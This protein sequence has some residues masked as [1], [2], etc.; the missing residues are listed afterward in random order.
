MTEQFYCIGEKLSH[1]WS[2]E[3]HARLGDY[4]YALREL[5]PDEVGPFLTARRF[6]GLNVTI[7]YKQTVMPYLDGIDES[8]AR[9]GAVNTIVNRGGK[10]YGYNTDFFGMTE[11]LARMR[12]SLAGKNVAILGTGGTSKTAAAVAKSQ[13]AARVV[14]VSRNPADA[15][16][17]SYAA[18]RETANEWQF[19]IN[20][21]PVGMYPHDGPMPVNP[22]DFP[23]LCGVL[24]AVYHPLRTAFVQAAQKCGL[25]AV[26]GLYML[27]AQAAKA[28]ALFFGDESYLEKI[29][30]VTASLIKNKENIVLIGMPGS[31]KTTLGKRLAQRMQ[32]PFIDSDAELEKRLGTTIPAYFAAHTESEFR[33]AESAVL[34]DLCRETGI[35]LATGG[36][37]VTVPENVDVLRRDGKVVFLDRSLSL[38]QGTADRPLTPNA[39]ALAQK[40]TERLPLYRAAADVIL[41]ADGTIEQ[42]LSELEALLS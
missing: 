2:V 17:I 8:A 12:V 26:G 13:G 38:L 34:R 29:D 35:V 33:A 11:L 15:D 24:D 14:R 22:A 39:A 19:I 1:S 41:S 21:T 27:V 7:P 18:L 23:A 6:A 40:Y 5:T 36:G 9:I 20:T 37:C 4:P 30:A 3:I 16:Q 31:G 42:N 10:L 28:A 25:P 32:R